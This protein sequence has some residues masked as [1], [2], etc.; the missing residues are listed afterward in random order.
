MESLTDQ[1]TQEDQNENEPKLKTKSNDRVT[2]GKNES[3]KVERWLKQIMDSSKGFLALNKSD[4]VNFLIREHRDDL[5]AQQHKRLKLDNYDPIKHLNWLSPLIKEALVKGD[6]SRVAELQD[7]LRGVELSVASL[8]RNSKM[9]AIYLLSDPIDQKKMPIKI[10]KKIKSS[11][12]E[13]SQKLISKNTNL[14][15]K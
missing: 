10:T 9:K 1:F 2:L 6:I 11:V 8:S 4:V 5:T 12:E 14:P 7:E 13:I 15:L 3:E